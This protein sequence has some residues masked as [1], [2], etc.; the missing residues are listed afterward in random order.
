MPY[1]LEFL[2]KNTDEITKQATQI[3]GV[4]VNLPEYDRKDRKGGILTLMGLRG[5]FLVGFA[6]GEVPKNDPAKYYEIACKKCRL[7]HN[8]HYN[9]HFSDEK[10]KPPISSFVRRN[11]KYEIYGGGIPLGT[12]YSSDPCKYNCGFLAFSGLPE[13]ADEALVLVLALDM[14]WIKLDLAREIA[15]ASTNP[16]FE[17]LLKASRA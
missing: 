17:A 5:S 8:L 4:L 14:E 16:Y 11:E 13:L 12:F 1:A 3:L 2:G 7:L 15:Q 9:D 10:E 6:I